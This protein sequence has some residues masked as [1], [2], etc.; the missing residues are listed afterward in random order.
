MFRRSGRGSRLEAVAAG[1][2]GVVA[3]I[4]LM[5]GV[6][7]DWPVRL[8]VVGLGFLV[9]GFLAGVRA[10]DNRMRHAFGAA[11]AGFLLYGAFV[12]LAWLAH[13]IG[14]SPEPPGLVPD[15]ANEPVVTAAW[16][17]LAA[18]VGG[19]VAQ[20]ALRPSRPSRLGR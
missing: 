4:G 1:W 16:A 12:V 20:A 5:V 3:A 7:R 11:V 10:G 14:S 8:A 2:G 19:A 18:L 9:G 6:G 13:G 15:G 17:V